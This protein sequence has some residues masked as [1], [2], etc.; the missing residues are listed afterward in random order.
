MTAEIARSTP[1]SLSSGSDQIVLKKNLGLMNGV[2]IIVGVIVGSGIFISPK[3]V[4][5]HSHSVGLSLLIWVACG[6]LSLV[7]ALCYAELGTAI[8]KSGGDYAY[9]REAF[10][11]LPA[12]LFLW[13]SMFVIMPTGNAIAAL[14]FANYLVAPYFSYINC[15]APTSACQLIAASLVCKFTIIY[16]FCSF[17]NFIFVSGYFCIKGFLTFI[18]CYNVKWSAFLMDAFTFAKVF[19]LSIIIGVGFYQMYNGKSSFF[20]QFFLLVLFFFFVYLV[21]LDIFV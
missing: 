8:P 1:G 18:N 11:D 10:G 9:I 14:T 15:I 20:K 13:V 3:G 5:E 7:G 6:V 4:L 19:A 12:F 16:F 17:F 2:C 21:L